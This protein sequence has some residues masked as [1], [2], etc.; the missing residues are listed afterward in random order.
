MVKK[1]KYSTRNRRHYSIDKL[2]KELLSVVRAMIIK[3]Q[4]PADF[5]EHYIGS[6]RYIDVYTYCKQK[7]HTISESAIARYAQRISPLFNQEPGEVD[8]VW[9]YGIATACRNYC[10]TVDDLISCLMGTYPI[11]Q[12][13]PNIQ[14]QAVRQLKFI[15]SAITTA[16]PL[17][18]GDAGIPAGKR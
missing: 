16:K 11:E 18:A 9:L 2:P 15:A 10:E 13:L 3:R 14:K 12:A 8:S 7:G 6:P 5:K 17:D 1:Q 4:W